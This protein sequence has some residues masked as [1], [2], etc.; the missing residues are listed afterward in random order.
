MTGSAVPEPD[1]R[2]PLGVVVVALIQFLR[3]GFLITQLVGANL[4]PG[5]EW[6]H[7]AIQVPDPAPGSVAFVISRGLA[8]GLLVA[9]LVV[10]IGLLRRRRWAWIGAILISGLGLA[11]AIGAWWDGDSQ[12]VS[13][14]INVVA[15]F[16][17]N[18]R[19]VRAAFDTAASEVPTTDH[20]VQS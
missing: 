8:I 13:M 12:Y 7:L 6:L 20:V 4:F 19:E 1:G 5:Q 15:V 3:S 10:G 9:S 11:F 16:Y 2:R 18:Q 14:V 17:L